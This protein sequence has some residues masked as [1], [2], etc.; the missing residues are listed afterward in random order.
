MTHFSC[1]VEATCLLLTTGLSPEDLKRAELLLEKF[2]ENVPTLYGHNAN[3]LNVH[4]LTHLV[5]FVRQWG[6]LWAWSCFS[7]ESFNDEIKKSVH[8]TGNVCKQIFWALQAQK[9]VESR[10]CHAKSGR[11]HDFLKRLHDS[12]GETASTNSE[13]YQ[14][15]VIKSSK[16][17]VKIS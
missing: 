17:Q 5:H 7:F 11:V 1:L 4:N 10:S 14:C 15:F 3:S 6:P 9:R 2:V 13:A 16:A 8:E 12:Q